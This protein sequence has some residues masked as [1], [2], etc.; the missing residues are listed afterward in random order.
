M[1]FFSKPAS[2]EAGAPDLA[3][4]LETLA[5]PARQHLLGQLQVP[6]TVAE[7][8]V[9]TE[10]RPLSRQAKE[11]H[12]AAL[13]N[14]GLVR[15][16]AAR[17]NGRQVREYVV[18][19]AGVFAFVEAVRDM[20]YMRPSTYA[21]DATQD[22][23]LQM[24]DAPELKGPC[25]VAV[26]GPMDGRRFGLDGPGPWTIGRLRERDVPITF[27]PF[28]SGENSTIRRDGDRWWVADAGTSRNGTWVDYRRLPSGT[29]ARLVSGALIG[30]GRSL[31]V[32]RA[33]RP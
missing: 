6:R 9:H 33:D 30:V 31:L 21:Q 26:G 13:R 4:I 1:A 17:R 32:F 10:G 7:M 8:E 29:E 25:L 19:Q 2:D 11:R 16:R 23:S 24:P 20:T 22:G 14:V 12:L 18:N 28:L 3:T 27:D 5:H 15:G